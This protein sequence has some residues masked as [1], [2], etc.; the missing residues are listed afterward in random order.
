MSS[1]PANLL[2]WKKELNFH[3]IG[4]AH[5][6][7]RR[8]IV[9]EH[10]YGCHDV[11]CFCFAPFTFRY[12]HETLR[13]L[14]TSFIFIIAIIQTSLWRTIVLY[15]LVYITNFLSFH[16]GTFAK[17]LT[18]V[19]NRKGLNPQTFFS[20]QL[21]CLSKIIFCMLS[22]VLDCFTCNFYCRTRA[23]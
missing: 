18:D 23:K 16:A 12:K 19:L 17:I 1:S 11:M 7:G 6:H 22:L 14:S 15:I 4:L 10:Q 21:P 8:F 13:H 2:E 20:M 9:L 3:R 5:K